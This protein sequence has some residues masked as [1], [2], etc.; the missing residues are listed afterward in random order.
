[1]YIAASADGSALLLNVRTL[2]V[3]GGRRL[4]KSADRGATWRV[5]NATFETSNLVIDPTDPNRMY[6]VG[7]D[8][9]TGSYAFYRSTD[10]G[11]NWAVV[12]TPGVWRVDIDPTSPAHLLG[13]QGGHVYS[14]DDYGSTWREVAI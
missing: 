7:T 6:A 8:N 12:T 10:G 1:L 11:F 14:S 13:A 9:V 5:A 2:D 4:L 3:S